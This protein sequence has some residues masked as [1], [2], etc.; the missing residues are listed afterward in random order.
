MSFETWLKDA[1]ILLIDDDAGIIEV[2][3]RMLG[4]DGFA[5]VETVQSP[6]AAPEA[7]R[8]IQPDLVILDYHMPQVNGLMLLEELKSMIGPSTYL[9]V[10]MM[11]AD[12]SIETRQ[13]ALLFGAADF[14]QKPVERFEL[15]YRIRNLLRTR[16]L[17]L[18]LQLDG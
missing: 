3:V 5:Q 13:R 8:T 2:M 6:L 7:F 15:V 18:Q 9:P 14:L 11:T 10:V 1:Q 16:Y 17:H 12:V 4:A